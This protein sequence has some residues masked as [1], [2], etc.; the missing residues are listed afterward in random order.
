MTGKKKERRRT[1]RRKAGE[2]GGRLSKERRGRRT[3][4]NANIV[5]GGGCELDISEGTDCH[6]KEE[7]PDGRRPR[8][9]EMKDAW[10]SW[11][12]ARYGGKRER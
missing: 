9:S 5:E 3:L 1:S 4:A 6:K 8:W 10:N 11:K 12:G 2:E 7:H